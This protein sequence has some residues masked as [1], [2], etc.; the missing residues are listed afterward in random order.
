VECKADI[1]PIILRLPIVR[2]KKNPYGI[3]I[4]QPRSFIQKLH[5][6]IMNKCC[7]CDNESAIIQNWLCLKCIKI[8]LFGE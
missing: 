8:A 1:I 4:L 7:K 6:I 5:N 2:F 3:S